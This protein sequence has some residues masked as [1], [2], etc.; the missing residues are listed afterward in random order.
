MRSLALVL[1]ATAALAAAPAAPGASAPFPKCSSIQG[2]APWTWYD[3]HSNTPYH[4]S[5][6]SVIA[7]GLSCA[8][9]KDYI[10]MFWKRNPQK[11]WEVGAMRLKGTPRGFNNCGASVTEERNRTAK[12]GACYGGAGPD[13]FQHFSWDP[14]LHR[15]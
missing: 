5:R 6:Y 11:K 2:P 15:R 8:K 10:R 9:A 12:S 1:V 4:G 3:G 14:E 7:E 13:S